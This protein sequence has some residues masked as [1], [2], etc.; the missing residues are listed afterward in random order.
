MRAQNQEKRVQKIL[1][2]LYPRSSGWLFGNVKKIEV[3]YYT[4]SRGYKTLYFDFVPNNVNQKIFLSGCDGLCCRREMFVPSKL[5]WMLWTWCE[6]Q[7]LGLK[8][9]HD[10]A[11]ILVIRGIFSHT[12][13]RENTQFRKG[14]SKKKEGKNSLLSTLFLQH[15]WNLL[16]FFVSN[17]VRSDVILQILAKDTCGYINGNVS[18]LNAMMLL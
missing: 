3:L 10:I 16:N 4:Q 2:N 8:G 1:W 9:G 14:L 5:L 6:R 17:N 12:Q 15:S 7:G 13:P 11:S 18:W